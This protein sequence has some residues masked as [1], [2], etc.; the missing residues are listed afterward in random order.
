MA[1]HISGK[2]GLISEVKEAHVQLVPFKVHADCDA[3][4]SEYFNRYVKK[5]DNE[6]N[7]INNLKHCQ[8]L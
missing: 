3:K 1:I 2:D 6:G 8:E 4:V 7:G 5:K